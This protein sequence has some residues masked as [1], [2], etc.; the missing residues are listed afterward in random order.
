MPAKSDFPGLQRSSPRK[1]GSVALHWA[2]SHKA[3]DAGYCPK[4]V[5]LHG[6]IDESPE[7]SAR[8]HELWAEMEKWLAEQAKPERSITYNGTVGSLI[9]TYE[10]HEHSPYQRLARNSKENADY[11][12]RRL[13]YTVAERRVPKLNGIDFWRWYW[14]FRKPAY[15]GGPE[16]IT[17]AFHIMARVRAVFTFGVL[18]RLPDLQE[19][20]YILSLIRFPN[21]DSRTQAMNFQQACDFIAQAHEFDYPEMA[22]A[23][24]LEFDLTLRQI[25][26]IGKWEFKKD[27]R[28]TLEWVGLR[29][30]KINK[31]LI[32]SYKTSK[33][34][35]EVVF[36]LKAYELVYAELCRLPTLPPFGPIIVDSETGRPFEYEEFRKRW[37]MI[38]RAAGIPDEVQNRDSRPGGITEAR[39]AGADGTTSGSRLATRK[40]GRRRSIS[41][42]LWKPRGASLRNVQH[43]GLEKN[44]C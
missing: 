3:R 38:A 31:D 9:T 34:G 10:T 21:P 8:C 19:L 5:R 35:R 33:R 24:A 39:N 20:R 7:L 15:E 22:L 29:W 4:T 26:V 41:E 25:D 2:C 37:R 17:D 28:N 1:A 42:R 32:L 36:D 30:E 27:D 18:L 6:F 12:L 11:E 13:K 44:K 16:R 14:E 23:Q 43:F 40:V